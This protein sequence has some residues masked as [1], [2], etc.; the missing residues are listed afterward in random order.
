M[1]MFDNVDPS[2]HL[3]SVYVTMWK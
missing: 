3:I 1:G 2:A